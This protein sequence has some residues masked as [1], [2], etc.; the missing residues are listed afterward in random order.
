[1]ATLI[2][3]QALFRFV[4]A[5]NFHTFTGFLLTLYLFVFGIAL[6]CIEC[7][8]MRARVWFYFMNFALGKAMFYGVMA[9]IC[10]GSGASVN[11]FDILIGIICI[12]VCIMFGFFHLWFHNEENAYVQ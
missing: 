7:N 9:L 4:V 5:D 10:F 2:I 1:M 3:I 11:F 8:L 12:G 6:I